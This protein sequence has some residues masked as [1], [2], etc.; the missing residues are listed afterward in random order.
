MD[1]AVFFRDDTTVA[2]SIEV[3]GAFFEPRFEVVLVRD[4]L[5]RASYRGFDG[6]RN[7]WLDWLE[8]WEAY[9]YDLQDVIEA[10]DRVATVTRNIGRRA[11][12]ERE[13]EFMAIA[14]YAFEGDRITRIEFHFDH[15]E[16]MAALF[17]AARE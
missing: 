3:A 8:P 2:A 10:G 4:D 11:G 16:G 15:D 17:A 6:L 9:R 5:G 7:A 13:V 1:L 14:I 12:M